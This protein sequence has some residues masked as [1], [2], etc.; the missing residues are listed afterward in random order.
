MSQKCCSAAPFAALGAALLLLIP[1]CSRPEPRATRIAVLRF[2]N[3]SGDASLDW[4][5]RAL[6]EA[7]A[8]AASG[9]REAWVLPFGVIRGSDAVLGPRPLDAPGVSAERSQALLAGAT[10]LILGEYAVV[11]GRL[12]VAAS[13]EDAASGKIVRAAAAAGTSA[14][15]IAGAA[16]SLA[17]GLGGLARPLATGN[18]DALRSFAEGIEQRR[19]AE[20]LRLFEKAVAADRGFGQ[21]WL[22]AIAT[23]ARID[24][25]A[26]RRLAERALAAREAMHPVERAKLDLDLAGL[27]G[28]QTA[29]RNALAALIAVEP[30]DPGPYRALA[31]LL[32]TG[33]EF[34]KAAALLRTAASLHP[35]DPGVLNSLG[36]AEA[37][38]GNLEAAA[39]ALRRYRQARPEDPNALD[40]LGDVHLHLRKEAEAERFYLDAYAMDAGFQDGGPLLKACFARLFAGDAGGAG[41]LFERYIE[42]RRAAGDPLVEYRRAEW[43]WLTGQ[44]RPAVEKLA[45]FAAGMESGERELAARAHAHLAI[46]NLAL[47][48]RDAARGHAKKALGLA[49]PVSQPMASAA[50][51]LT[52]PP[53]SAGE[54]AVRAER[55]FQEPAQRPLQQF[56]LACA[57]LFERQFQPASLVLNDIHRQ[58]KPVT[59]DPAIPVLLAWALAASGRPAEAAPLVE[60]NPVPQGAGLN[61]FTALWFPRL[62]ALRGQVL[63]SQGRTAEAAP[64][65]RRFRD[66]SGPEPTVW[67]DGRPARAAL[68]R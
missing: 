32:Q 68:A 45:L 22:A 49:G 11:G 39:A 1:A 7:L 35:D 48:G 15:D 19:P 33:R 30:A 54:W 5:G 42:G 9:S 56:A 28:D 25:A 52:E 26:A 16:A 66:L 63:E 6:S 40:S 61:P 34:E 44:R 36:Y 4:M 67:D 20:A 62:F 51:F 8:S 37:W 59:S 46:W 13:I 3:L 14:G 12:R 21:A 50:A 64:L 58:W 23:A 43:L 29:Q 31:S 65:Y 2:E 10:R 27:R 38:T 24:P 47:G 41:P 18:P 60:R 53:A 57:L 17:L 55:A